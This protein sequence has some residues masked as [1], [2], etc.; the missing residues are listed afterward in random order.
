[1]ED[2]KTIFIKCPNLRWTMVKGEYCSAGVPVEQNGSGLPAPSQHAE[3]P[4]GRRFPQPCRQD[5]DV[6]ESFQ[7]SNRP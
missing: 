7:V 5:I 2:L 3:C 4:L 1:M 6:P